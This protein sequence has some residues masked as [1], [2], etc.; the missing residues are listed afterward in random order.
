MTTLSFRDVEL[1]S[2][3]ID[4]A[5]RPTDS[6]R[7][8]AR[9]KSDPNLRAVMDDLR[10]ARGVLRKLP[11]RKSPRNF[12]LTP[13]MAG[14]KPPVPRTYPV[15]RFASALATLLLL[16]TF[17]INGITLP[18]AFGASAP[19]TESYALGAGGGEAMDEALPAEPAIQLLPLS[20]PEP[21]GATRIAETATLEPL[22]KGFAQEQAD[23]DSARPI[24]STWQAGLLIVAL[25]LG[26]GAW[27]VRFLNDQ[28]W[29]ARK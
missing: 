3:Y 26:A 28:K 22:P 25:V 20:T 24:P 21:A 29:R 23:Q 8:E 1:L 6:A 17:A 15:L 10:A 12:T 19:A 16:F 13:K 7:L 11:P 4:G 5:L 14:I 9:L 2:A 27:L 18:I